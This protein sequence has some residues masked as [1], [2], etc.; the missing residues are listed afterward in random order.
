MALLS[1]CESAPPNAP[2]KPSPI[3]EMS[4]NLPGVAWVGGYWHWD[5][6]QWV[7]IAGHIAPKL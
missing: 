6:S 5:G 3:A 2:P 7:W 4:P 1:A